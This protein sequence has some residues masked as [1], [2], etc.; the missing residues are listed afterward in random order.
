[1]LVND[2]YVTAN[3][4]S[5]TVSGAVS[6]SNSLAISN[7]GTGSGGVATLTNS[8]S[9]FSGAIT[10]NAGATLNSSNSAHIGSTLGSGQLNLAGGALAIYDDNASNYG[11]NINVTA[12]SSLSVN[13]ATT[14]SGNNIGFNNVALGGNT[15]TV[16]ATGGYGLQINGTLSNGGTLAGNS[17]VTVTGVVAPGDAPALMSVAQMSI[18][19][20]GTYR[21][22][23]AG[24]P[25]W[26]AGGNHNAGTTYDSIQMSG[27][28]VLGVS[29]S[30]AGVTLNLIDTE[31]TNPNV[32]DDF[33][34]VVNGSNSGMAQFTTV[35]FD[36]V[37]ATVQGTGPNGGEVYYDG[38]ST[39]FGSFQFELDYDANYSTGALTGG[40]DLAVAVQS[41]PEPSALAL[42]GLG[43]MGLLARRRRRKLGQPS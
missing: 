1:L 12:N 42:I 13:P 29:T 36:G 22:E 6:G 35:E 40:N 9:G 18:S 20:G 26:V 24:G 38:S 23:L 41:V 7:S 34:V 4:E 21:A 17:P 33:F 10:I 19:A 30:G 28:T 15:L 2:P 25:G 43:A 16:N 8:N 39:N 3:A 27:G 5:F 14:G 37:V 31:Y 11:N 32:G